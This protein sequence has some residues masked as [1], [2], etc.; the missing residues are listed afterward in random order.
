M[1]GNNERW[2][3][4]YRKGTC[5]AAVEEKLA[6]DRTEIGVRVHGAGVRLQAVLCLAQS[7]SGIE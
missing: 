2:I 6:S 1:M 7:S 5:V 3:V 4:I